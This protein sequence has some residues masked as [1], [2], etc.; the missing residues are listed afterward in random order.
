MNYPLTLLM[1]DPLPTTLHLVCNRWVWT[2]SELTFVVWSITT[3]TTRANL[4]RRFMCC[5]KIDWFDGFYRTIDF[6]NKRSCHRSEFLR[7]FRT[8]SHI[9][10]ILISSNFI[11]L[12]LLSG[13]VDAPSQG[14]SKLQ[15]A[16]VVTCV[17]HWKVYYQHHLR[18]FYYYYLRKNFFV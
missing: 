7:R 10:T 5:D 1:G 4:S 17:C 15:S 16:H 3:E 13:D 18:H 9:P 14:R 11:G 2:K 12:R 6:L 8:R